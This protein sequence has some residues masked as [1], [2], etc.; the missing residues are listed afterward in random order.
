MNTFSY[1]RCLT[2]IYWKLQVL[3]WHR[4]SY[5]CYR[6]RGLVTWMIWRC[7][8]HL[9]RW[10]QLHLILKITCQCHL[11]IS[12]HP[13]H[14]DRLDVEDV[15]GVGGHVVPVDMLEIISLF[16]FLLI[17]TLRTWL[18]IIYWFIFIVIIFV[19]FYKICIWLTS[20]VV[21]YLWVLFMIFVLYTSLSGFDKVILNSK[22]VLQHLLNVKLSH[23]Q[24]NVT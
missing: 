4:W 13:Y 3:L 20:L 19:F 17:F 15:L 5:G 1:R 18:T 21:S 10:V 23:Y 6:Y 24:P 22:W 14:P 2:N 7:S 11:I 12:R 16:I 8:D 9:N